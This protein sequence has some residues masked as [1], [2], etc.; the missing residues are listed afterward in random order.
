MNN[1]MRYNAILLSTTLLY[2]GLACAETAPVIY[3]GTN[4]NYAQDAYSAANTVLQDPD[5]KKP[6]IRVGH[7]KYQVSEITG[8]ELAEDFETPRKKLG[9]FFTNMPSINKDTII[10]LV[11]CRTDGPKLMDIFYLRADDIG[12][13]GKIF[14][15]K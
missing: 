11:T 8:H 1:K 5:C 12:Q 13:P 2:S 15:K 14:R 4:P 10:Y 9:Q 3:I 7:G 6:N